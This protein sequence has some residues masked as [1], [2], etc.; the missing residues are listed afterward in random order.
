M[1][2]HIVRECPHT[3]GF[4]TRRFRQSFRGSRNHPD[5]TCDRPLDLQQIP[6]V[7]EDRRRLLENAQR[8]VRV[9][10]AFAMEVGADVV[11]IGHCRPVVTVEMGNLEEEL[12]VG[13]FVP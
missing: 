8:L 7:A 2:A 6:L 13:W 9:E 10:P 4:E 3:L 11:G 12:D 5:V 1:I